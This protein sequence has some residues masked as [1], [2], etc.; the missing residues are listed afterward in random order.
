MVLLLAA[1]HVTSTQSLIDSFVDF[2]LPSVVDIIII[3]V[4][5]QCSY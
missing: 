5:V 2:S 4:V 3:V 1:G